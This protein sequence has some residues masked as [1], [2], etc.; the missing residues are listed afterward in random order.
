MPTTPQVEKQGTPVTIPWPA[1][2]ER[3]EAASSNSSARP[4]LSTSRVGR[5]R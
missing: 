4:P 3:Y 5:D 2:I 1:D